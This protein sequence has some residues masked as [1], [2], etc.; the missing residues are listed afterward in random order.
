MSLRLQLYFAVGIALAILGRV[1]HYRVITRYLKSRG[2]PVASGSSTFS[3]WKEW[4]AYKAARRS[5]NQS[6]IWWYVLL[7]MG[8]I[9]VFY[10]AGWFCIVLGIIRIDSPF[11]FAGR[12]VNSSGYIT[13][14]D[15]TQAG[16]RQ[17]TFPFVGVL[18]IAGGLAMRPLVR[19][20]IY[21]PQYPWMM[22]WFPRLFVGFAIVWTLISFASTFADYRGAVSALQDN[23]ARVVEGAV[24]EFKPIP[25]T[26][27]GMESFV[28]QGVRFKY[29]N[30][31]VT[32]G[33]NTTT[34]HGGPIREGLPVKIWYSD[35]KILR[36][37]VKRGPGH[38]VATG[39]KP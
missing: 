38:A 24:T 30:Y 15:V 39:S 28:V 13:V 12:A 11:D 18:L 20:G 3:D 4:K 23:R 26:G 37:D 34:A 2:L 33:F 35:G 14:F 27:K 29:S 5:E 7:A 8:I 22:K 36:L 6:I 19:I 32:A 25:Y 9:G 17:W 1:I 31:D 21:R 10:V 16:F